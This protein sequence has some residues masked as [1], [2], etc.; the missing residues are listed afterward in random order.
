[1]QPE[2]IPEEL[3]ETIRTCIGLATAKIVERRVSDI[4]I[5]ALKSAEAGTGFCY[6]VQCQDRRK[7]ESKTRAIAFVF[8]G[9]IPDDLLD[10]IQ[11][12]LNG[13][14][15]DYSNNSKDVRI[16]FEKKYGEEPED[17]EDDE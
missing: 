5:L 2:D 14:V 8:C 12:Y 11:S 17:N 16:L 6:G 10:M 4:G 13:A 3:Q 9:D 1:M 7:P 15:Q